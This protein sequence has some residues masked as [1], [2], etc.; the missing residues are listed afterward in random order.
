ME[1]F[2][3]NERGD[4]GRQW[5]CRSEAER[6]RR[7]HDNLRRV[8]PR[9]ARLVFDQIRCAAD[10]ARVWRR[11][12]RFRFCRTAGRHAAGV[13][14]PRGRAFGG[15]MLSTCTCLS[16]TCA[17]ASKER[18]HRGSIFSRASQV[19][20]PSSRDHPQTSRSC[21]PP[22]RSPCEGAAVD[23]SSTR[24]RDFRV[25]SATVTRRAR[26]R[27]P[28][29]ARASPPADGTSCARLESSKYGAWC[30][31]VVVYGPLSQTR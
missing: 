5:C 2:G 24:C 18:G 29:P 17:S 10:R 23:G 26:P 15:A 8:S 16:V 6:P 3:D 30:T 1:E 9:R 25:T 12:L 11:L 27:K 13:S 19:Q 22:G 31:I 7:R 28:R 4:S 14:C 21:A 20:S